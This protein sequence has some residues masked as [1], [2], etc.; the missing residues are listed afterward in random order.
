VYE[1]TYQDLI[2]RVSPF[3]IVEISFERA[4]EISHSLPVEYLERNPYK[5]KMK[6]DK[7]EVKNVI[8]IMFRHYELEDVTI[9]E[10]DISDVVEKIYSSI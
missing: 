2:N 7:G 8:G 9:E 6:I 10:E 3:K 5:V 1:G 4:T